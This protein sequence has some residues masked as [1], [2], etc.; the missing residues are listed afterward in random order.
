MKDG[1]KEKVDEFILKINRGVS[2]KTH[3]LHHSMDGYSWFSS[4]YLVEVIKEAKNMAFKEAVLINDVWAE[5][6]L[7]CSCQRESHKRIGL[8]LKSR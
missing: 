6:E 1:V 2:N 4:E 5:N 8:W 3:L 7:L